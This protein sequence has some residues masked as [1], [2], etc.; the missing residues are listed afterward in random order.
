MELQ[1]SILLFFSSIDNSFFNKLVEFITMFGETTFTLAVV[2]FVL[3]CIDKKKGALSTFI[4]FAATTFMHIL[5]AIVRF[6]RPWAVIPELQT[7]RIKTATGYSFPSGHSTTA[8]SIYSALAVA[9]KK[10]PISIICA[11]L[12]LLV[13]ISRLYLCVHWPLD[14]FCGTILGIGTTAVFMSKFDYIYEHRD[15]YFK[16]MVVVGSIIAATGLV[17]A[18]LIQTEKID[19]LAFSDFSK[20]SALVGSA[21]A[22]FAIEEKYC[23]F[24]VDGTWGKKILRLAVGFAV[25]LFI[26]EGVKLFTPYTPVMS[27]IRYLAAGLWTSLYPMVG[28]K[29]GLFN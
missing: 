18:I 23:N 20:N 19:A 1:K 14:V 15:K 10:R 8:S 26:L 13:P 24:T 17:M 3:W 16:H 28:K 12:I 27:F 7:G 29:I 5:K 9:F 25:A 21:L 2:L 11:V 22:G 6:P 4:M